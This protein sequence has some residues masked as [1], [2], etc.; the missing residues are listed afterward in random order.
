MG[1]PMNLQFYLVV[2]FLTVECFSLTNYEGE[3]YDEDYH[4]EGDTENEGTKKHMNG[5]K[6]KGKKSVGISLLGM[7]DSESHLFKNDESEYSEGDEV[8]QQGFLVRFLKNIH[9]HISR[10]DTRLG[11][12]E[13]RLLSIDQKIAQSEKKA[14]T[15][16]QCLHYKW[17]NESDRHF[18]QG[19]FGEKGL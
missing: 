10:I 1:I 4:E 18:T 11:M 6:D 19:K 17:L 15:P 2:I 12:V 5:R 3:D 14:M 9:D 16:V 7:D 8:E 13:N